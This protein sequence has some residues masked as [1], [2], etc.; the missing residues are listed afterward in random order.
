MAVVSVSELVRGR[1]RFSR[2]DG[3]SLTR[4]YH[5]EIDD[6]SVGLRDVENAT[7]PA[8][9]VKVPRI[10]DAW[11]EVDQYGFARVSDIQYEQLSESDATHYVAYVTY[12]T[13]RSDAQQI[14]LNPYAR[15]S[16]I[17]FDFEQVVEEWQ[18]AANGA[19]IRNSAGEPIMFQ[20][21][22]VRPI[23]SVSR[24]EHRFDW[25]QAVDFSNAV[26]SNRWHI[27]GGIA[28]P[29]EAKCK[30][31]TADLQHESGLS[32]FLVTYT[33]YF[34][35]RFETGWR[36]ALLDVGNNEYKVIDGVRK[37]VPIVEAPDVGEPARQF[38]TQQLLNGHGERL[39]VGGSAYYMVW[40]GSDVVSMQM[41]RNGY[42]LP[43]Q[44][45]P[46]YKERNFDALGLPAEL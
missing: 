6:S 16:T 30:T 10:G 1:R 17:R 37:L 26:N 4:V 8:T 25:T 7:D 27:C 43:S 28:E 24:A 35:S 33:F 2:Q 19:L 21:D 41:P 46:V 12:E 38:Q 3:Y 31:I 18:H 13:A 34:K 39:P 14:E 44:G 23:L 36:L 9:S 32:F 5:V 45:I 40:G 29:G 15:P 11:L 22:R 42:F 20:V